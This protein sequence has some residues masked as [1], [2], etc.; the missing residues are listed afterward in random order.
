MELEALV[1]RLRGGTPAESADLGVRLCQHA[2]RSLYPCYALAFVP[3]LALALAAV[4]LA[5]WLPTLLLWWSKPWLDRTLLFVLARAAFG[6]PT[7][8][9]EVWA[10][11]RH[12][13]WEQLWRSW[14]L[15]RLSMSRA[16]TQPVYQLEQLRGSARQ[17]R[18]RQLRVGHIAASRL[19]TGTFS[20][21][22]TVLWVALL[23]LLFWFMPAGYDAS[24]LL[25]ALTSNEG[26]ATVVATTL[27]YAGVVFFLE[28][29]YAAAGFSMYLG[30]RVDL[31]AWDIE[32]ELRRAFAG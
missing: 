29:F 32:Q 24:H 7:R 28:P 17:R 26:T 18:L 11:R 21:A 27:I 25:D 31:E 5:P 12:V 23:S 2:A 1:L 16:F 14:T 3:L 22:E 6:L 15:R 13:W 30:R 4:P 8:P 19:L 9:R 10:A 20:T